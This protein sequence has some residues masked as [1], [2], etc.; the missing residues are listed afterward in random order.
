[1]AKEIQNF[2]ASKMPN[3][4]HYDFMSAVES[5]A[6]NYSTIKEKAA[7]QLAA[8][9]EKL[10]VEDEN[11]KLSR[12]NELSDQI[13]EQDRLRDAYYAGYKAAV[14]SM[15]GSVDEAKTLWQNIKDYGVNTKSQL[16]KETGDLTNLTA[17]L[18]GKLK[19]EVAALGLAELVAKLKTA[20]DSV[21]SLM[22]QRDLE[23][24]TR[25]A[26]ALKAARSETDDAYKA[27]VKR[28]NAL[29]E[30]DAETDYS[31]FIDTINEQ[32]ERYRQQVLAKKKDSPE[33]D[34]GSA[35]D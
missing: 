2:D 20:N 6:D 9:S 17:D 31:S 16:N 28:V 32:I 29:A 21:H 34:G 23:N 10:G 8:L 13:A 18:T 30:V 22:M 15:L 3:G 27:L 19:A 4:A 14:K 11:M 25:V 24:S 35:G 12:K 33:G 5:F 1:M 26:G 7:E